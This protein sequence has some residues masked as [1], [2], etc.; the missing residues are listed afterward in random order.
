MTSRD[1]LGHPS[2]SRNG[3]STVVDAIGSEVVSSLIPM[4]YSYD[5]V[6]FFTGKRGAL[7]ER[8]YTLEELEKALLRLS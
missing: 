2:D 5:S 8:T 6:H 7:F 4:G 1:Y 3:S